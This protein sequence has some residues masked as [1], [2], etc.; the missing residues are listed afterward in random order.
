[1][2]LKIETEI[3]IQIKQEPKILPQQQI[4]EE[5]AFSKDSTENSRN[6]K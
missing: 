6:R 1:M 4:L 3:V 2:P 5:L